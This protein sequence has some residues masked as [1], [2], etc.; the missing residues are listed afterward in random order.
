MNGTTKSRTNFVIVGTLA[1]V[2]MSAASSFAA[3]KLIVKDS[4]GTT[5]KFV[6]TDSGFIG[7]GTNAPTTS[8][9]ITGPASASRIII[10]SQE[11]TAAGG[12]GF[13]GV[14]NNASTVN[15]S[16][17]Q[18]NDRLGY[19]LYGTKYGGN[20]YIGGGFSVQAEA[21]WTTSS[22]PTYY[23]FQTAPVGSTGRLERMRITSSGNIGV[24]TSAPAQKLEVNGGVRVNTTTTK[25][26]CTGSPT[27]VR[28]TLWFTQGGTGVADTL[29]VCA[30]D[31]AGTY[32]WRTLY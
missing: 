21:N 32:A 23:S 15:S 10:G 26:D 18:K 13:I 22:L 25:P 11:T 7:S 3:N 17:P 20:F 31:A 9:E 27:T 24:G 28:G 30:K 19:L 29:E 14:H 5:D 2:C 16:F 12:G 6:V 1:L 4:T 8:L